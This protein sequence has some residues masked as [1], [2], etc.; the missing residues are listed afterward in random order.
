M[1]DTVTI[2]AQKRNRLHSLR[3]Y[4]ES[5]TIPR[6]D[7]LETRFSMHRVLSKSG[8]HGCWSRR[9][10]GNI[11]GGTR[12]FLGHFQCYSGSQISSESSREKFV[13]E[14]WV[15]S[16]TCLSVC[17]CAIDLDLVSERRLGWVEC[18]LL[19]FLS[20]VHHTCH[21][22][23]SYFKLYEKININFHR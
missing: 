8:R 14:K 22:W 13:T 21:N 7:E 18:G 4:M 20:I 10:R 15:W 23:F 6:E 19:F 12:K 17:V 3:L 9:P 5:I 2:L 1:T 11:Q 16:R